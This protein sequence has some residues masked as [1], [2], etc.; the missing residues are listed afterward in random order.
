MVLVARAEA[1]KLDGVVAAALSARKAATPARNNEGGVGSGLEHRTPGRMKPSVGQS[2]SDGS[3]IPD[4]SKAGAGFTGTFGGSLQAPRPAA[5]VMTAPLPPA[6]DRPA[7]S[8]VRQYPSH[9]L[10][11][12]STADLEPIAAL[13]PASTRPPSSWTSSELIAM[14]DH[15]PLG[16]MRTPIL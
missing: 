1:S 14:L 6:V 8:G 11:P 4:Q 16:T 9:R 13:T 12:D 10:L 2:Y 15:S 3:S 7:G 5:P